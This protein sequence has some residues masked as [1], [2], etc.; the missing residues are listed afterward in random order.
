VVSFTPRLLFPSGK[1]PLYPLTKRL[2]GLQ[3]RSER[4]GIEKNLLLLSGIELRLS[5]PYP[6]AILTALSQLFLM[7]AYRN[8]VM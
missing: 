6:V 8:E 7:N 3:S 1:S 2:G 5:S 4:C